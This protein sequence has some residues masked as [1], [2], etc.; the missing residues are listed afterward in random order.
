MWLQ[1]VLVGN[2]K[3]AAQQAGVNGFNSHYMQCIAQGLLY[4]GK[5]VPRLAFSLQKL[6]T[7]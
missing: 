5:F 6:L 3:T 1:H 7:W 4:V 2:G